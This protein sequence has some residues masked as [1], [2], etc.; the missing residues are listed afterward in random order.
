MKPKELKA[1]RKK[2]KLTQNEMAQAI[3]IGFVTYSRW[4]K[5]HNEIPKV[6]AKLFESIQ[7]LLDRSGKKEIDL[8]TEEISEAVK[9][10][11]VSGVVSNAAITN[12]IPKSHL[13]GLIASVPTFAW[14]GGALG[15]G[16]LGSLAFFGKTK[17][18]DNIK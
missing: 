10:V 11:G 5:G 12:L 13:L 14:I 2:L 4:E 8:K 3:N 15:I 1:I 7:L 9:N 6:P 16:V 18:C 17:K